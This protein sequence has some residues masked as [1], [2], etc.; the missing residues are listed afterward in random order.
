MKHLNTG[1]EG[2]EFAVRFLKKKGLRVIER[3]FRTPI[4]EIDIVAKDGKDIVIVE[5]K[6]RKG[7]QYGHPIEAVDQRKQ[8]RLRRLAQ[9]YLKIKGYQDVHVR[10]DVLGLVKKGNSFQVSYIKDAF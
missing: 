4:G 2:E 10:F 1:K 5:V 7:M 8:H 3:N 6:T 9:L